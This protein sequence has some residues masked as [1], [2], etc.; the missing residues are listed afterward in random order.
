[1]TCV[2]TGLKV[3]GGVVVLV[4][5]AAVGTSIL[6]AAGV[7]M[8]PAAIVVGLAPVAG[9]LYVVPLLWSV[10]AA[11]LLRRASPLVVG[12]ISALGLVA[13]GLWL[14]PFYV[15][16][17]PRYG[18]RLTVLTQN[19]EYG[20][21]DASAVVREIARSKVDVVALQELTPAAVSALRAAGIERLLPH[22]ALAAEPG[23]A[24]IGVWSRYPVSAGVQVPGMSFRSL[25]TT[26][27]Q[28]GGP[29]LFYAV[30]P[31][32]PL[33]IADTSRW[34]ADHSALRR[35]LAAERKKR[36]VV[37]GDFNA[38]PDHPA[39]RALDS[40][41]YLDAAD[42]AGAGVQP[43]WP[44]G[45][46]YPPLFAIDH[47]LVTSPLGVPSV[48]LVTVPGTDHRGVV[49]ELSQSGSSKEPQENIGKPIADGGVRRN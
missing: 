33:P 32:P 19:L 42:V 20:R 45:R 40:L 31:F 24:G 29:L 9:L 2:R 16:D 15:A 47:V 28:P 26:L 6:R 48:S 8:G 44:M 13:H 49:A 34:Q 27:T 7:S 12:G 18:E 21:A 35:A 39:M 38:T 10:L 23:A 46:S 36:V 4:L 3:T 14:L 41:G 25:S 37:A 22:A 30:H 11:A 43:T 1:M 17:A 5:L